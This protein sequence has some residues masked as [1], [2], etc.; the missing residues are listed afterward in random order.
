MSDNSD[1]QKTKPRSA[2]R[3]NLPSANK[4]AAG[5]EGPPE[6]STETSVKPSVPALTPTNFSV[7]PD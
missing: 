6:A 5:L 4:K 1:P 3:T 7:W 2:R